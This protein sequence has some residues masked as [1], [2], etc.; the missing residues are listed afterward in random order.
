MK[1]IAGRLFSTKRTFLQRLKLGWKEFNKKYDDDGIPVIENDNICKDE[2]L[3]IVSKK[4]KSEL[5]KE[6]LI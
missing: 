6:R 2:A 1:F 4:L 5:K 3:I